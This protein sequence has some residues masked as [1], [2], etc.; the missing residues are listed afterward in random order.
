MTTKPDLSRLKELLAK[1]TQLFELT[2]ANPRKCGG[3]LTIRDTRFTVAQLIAEIAD[4]RHDE[5]CDN[6]DLD[7]DDVMKILHSVAVA[8]DALQAG[9]PLIAALE[10]SEA[11]V[12]RLEAALREIS[13]LRRGVFKTAFVDG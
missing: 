9:A 3:K 12:A 11:K 8:I 1:A 6:Y 2:E 4:S 7:N 10:S 13:E 5:V